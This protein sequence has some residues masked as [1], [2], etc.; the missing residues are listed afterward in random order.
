MKHPLLDPFRHNVWATLTLIER[1]R[2]LGRCELTV[3]TAPGTYGTVMDTL[4]HVL[5]SEAGYR[6]RLTGAW[7]EWSW[8]GQVTPTL[9]DLRASTEESGRF[10]ED[11]LA[12]DREP[13]DVLPLSAPDGLRYQVPV[14]VILAQVLN[15]GNEH[16]GQICTVLSA[17]GVEPPVVDGWSYGVASGRIVP[18]TGRR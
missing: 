17:A 9:D 14:G 6:F 7:P 12:G 8:G 4:K 3:A 15:H 5:G 2:D 1:C 18:A 11:F 13:D 10:W 16:R